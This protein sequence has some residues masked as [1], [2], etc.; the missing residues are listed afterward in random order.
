MTDPRQARSYTHYLKIDELTRLQECLSA[1]VRHDE[2]LFIVIHQVFELW[3]KQ[4]LHEAV[5]IRELLTRGE[6]R[7]ATRLFRRLIEIQ[8]VLIQQIAVLETMTPVDFLE[9]RNHLMPASGLQSVQF[10]E[11]EFISGMK[12]RTIVG[13][14]SGSPEFKTRLEAR[15][16]EPS[17]LDALDSCLSS[18]GFDLTAEGEAQSDK[19]LE[20]LTSIY[21]DTARQYDLYLLCEAMIEYDENFRLWRYHHIQMVERMIGK[22]IG[23]GGTEGVGYLEKTL[24]KRCF[25]ELWVVRTHLGEGPGW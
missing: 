8:R 10:R 22:K 2:L 5:T 12:D 19:R 18:R 1:P 14:H 24:A 25:P 23:T 16:A 13:L 4:M 17:L 21:K 20:A 3:F 9:F 11:L 6:V 7:P 15:L